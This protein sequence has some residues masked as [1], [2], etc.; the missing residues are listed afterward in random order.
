[1]SG[2]KDKIEFIIKITKKYLNEKDYH[3]DAIEE[4]YYKDH[5]DQNITCIYYDMFGIMMENIGM[6]AKELP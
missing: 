6:K 3:K 1:M 2:R 5:S 4:K